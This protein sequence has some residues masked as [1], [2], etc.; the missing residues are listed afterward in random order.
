MHLKFIIGIITSNLQA[1]C[2]P[3]DDVKLSTSCV[4][5]GY[6]GNQIPGCLSMLSMLEAVF[7]KPCIAAANMHVLACVTS[8]EA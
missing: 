2:L 3:L 5:Q 1:A 8:F 6:Q 7:P 4:K